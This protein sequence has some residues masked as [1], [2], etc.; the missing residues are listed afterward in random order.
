[1]GAADYSAT[2]PAV[3]KRSYRV[4]VPTPPEKSS[5]K[6]A[7]GA[8]LNTPFCQSLQGHMATVSSLSVRRFP[9]KPL[10]NQRSSAPIGPAA[11][12]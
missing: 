10:Q 4:H 6:I 3:E 8:T 7:V 1:M 2:P 12:L 11:Q 9:S 5:H